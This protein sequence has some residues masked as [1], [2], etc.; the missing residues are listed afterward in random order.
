[1]RKGAI[2]VPY[3]IALILGIV[4]VGLLAYWFF[5]LGGRIG[6]QASESECRAKENI[7]CSTWSTTDYDLDNKPGGKD[8]SKSCPTTSADVYAPECCSF[9]WAH[10]VDEAECK[11][12]LGEV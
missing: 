10:N 1:M 8:F 5:V 11:S 9:S 2:P 12:V 7:Y 6:G 3:I 4:V